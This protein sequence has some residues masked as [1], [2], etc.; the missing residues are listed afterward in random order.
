MWSF[1]PWGL[2]IK[3]RAAEQPL[4]K[5]SHP[6]CW[7]SLKFLHAHLRNPER[8]PHVSPWC[9]LS[10]ATC[11]HMYVHI[12]IYTHTHMSHACYLVATATDALAD[13]PQE[14]I[15]S[16]PEPNEDPYTHPVP[17]LRPHSPNRNKAPTAYHSGLLSHNFLKSCLISEQ[18]DHIN[19]KILQMMIC[20]TPPLTAT[21]NEHEGSLPGLQNSAT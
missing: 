3:T 6:C 20:R 16:L 14:G 7:T 21:Y 5:K 11:I 12:C 17:K 19:T 4:R 13:F 8:G 1:D 2:L 15:I 18:K 9:M 10:L